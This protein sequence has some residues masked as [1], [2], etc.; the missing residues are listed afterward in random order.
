MTRGRTGA[1]VTCEVV[2]AVILESGSATRTG[3]VCF[4]CVPSP[5]WPDALVPQQK[6]APS[7]RVM[8]HAYAVPAERKVNV[9][10]ESSFTGR[11]VSEHELPLR[12]VA[13]G[14][15]APSCPD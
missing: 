9:R 11:G 5:S 10:P 13:L 3:V 1:R 6:I 2:C 4:V 12:H 7:G 8:P 15:E 14:D